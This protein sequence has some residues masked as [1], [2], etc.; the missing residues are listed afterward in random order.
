MKTDLRLTSVVPH[1]AGTSAECTPLEL[2][3][4]CLLEQYN[5]DIYKRVSINQIGDNLEEFVAKKQGN[6][7]HINI[8]YPVYNDFET[9]SIFERN[10]IRID[11]IHTA[12][13]RIAYDDKKLDEA[14]LT[15]IRNEILDKKFN[16]QFLIRIFENQKDK[17]LVAKLIVEPKFHQMN[18]YIVIEMDEKLKCKVHIYSGHPEVFFGEDFFKDGKWIN[19]NELVISGK[20]KEVTTTIIIDKCSMSV[21]NL[22]I[23][24][25]PPLYT[26]SKA[27]VTKEEKEYAYNL[28]KDSLPLEGRSMLG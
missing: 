8:R 15:L 7:I 27:N 10:R 20:K 16:F 6:Q 18:Y 14:K 2:I 3:Y 26:M 5:Q 21:R 28:W 1:G 4:S 22:T 12:L 23:H 17:S 9:R 13:C 11:L 19:E 25:I 24:D